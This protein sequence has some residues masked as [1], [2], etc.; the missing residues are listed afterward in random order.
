MA[1]GLGNKGAAWLKRELLLPFHQL[2]W[3]RKNHVGK[4][5]L[6]HALMVSDFMVALEL[7]CRKRSDVRLLTEDDLRLLATAP[8]GRNPFR[9]RVKVQD[10]PVCTVIPDRVFGLDHADGQQKWFA[11]EADRATMPV[12]RRSLEQSSFRRKML[13]YQATWA[14]NL[15]RQLGW[16]RFRVLTVT[17]DSERIRQMLDACHRLKQGQGLFLFTDIEKLRASPDV[18][19]LH[20]QTAKDAKITCLFN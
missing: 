6:E 9:W 20:W 10:G 2:E 13:A 11:L 5:F 15:H 19:S 14:Q 12:N 3:K 4:L 1:Y 17:T 16:Q 8:A 7:A 18:F